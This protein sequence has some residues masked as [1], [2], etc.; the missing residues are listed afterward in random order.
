MKN[1]VAAAGVIG[2][3]G[4]MPV[5]A[6]E[7]RPD[8]LRFRELYKELVETNTTLSSGSC[9]LAA[10]RMGA[11]L[12]AAGYADSQL[13]YFS[14]PDHPKEGG[15]VAVLPGTSK[16]AKPILLLAHID[17][18][19]ARRS[20]WQRDP[21]TLIEENGYFYARGATDDK[22]MASIWVELMVRLKQEGAKPKRTV[23]LALTCGEET[24]DA[25]NGAQWLAQNRP[26]LLAAEFA[27]NEGG[28]GR[29]DGKGKL[30]VQNIQVGEK[31][32]Q[33]YRLETMNPGGHSSMP[34]RDNAIY[35][36]ADALA[37]I[38]DHEFPIQLN[39]TTRAFFAKAGAARGGEMGQAMVAIAANPNDTAAEAV[40]NRDRTFHSLLRTT[41]V[42]TLLEGGH[43][44]NALPQHAGA[45]INCRIFP[46]NTV[47]ATQ[48]ALEQA[49]GNPKVKVTLVA[50]IRPL[51]KSPPLDPKVIGPMEKLAA[52]YYPGVPVIPSMSTGASDSVFL[53]AIGI[54]VYGV[55]GLWL[56]PDANGAHGL[57][58]RMEVRALYT[59]RDYLTELV[60]TYANAS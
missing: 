41:C 16:T 55:P 30:L 42:A 32:V 38:R 47:E 49:I 45:N 54:P 21:F 44:N 29:T 5:A 7:P 40:L 24:T 57:N 13:T 8:Q 1:R 34:V 53:N 48:A 3:L 28:G 60:K 14:V 4:A 35:E 25:F 11:R 56:D 19:D 46:G 51:A 36:L 27:L 43:A 31:A 33:N 2:L 6:Q 23:K 9:T 50:P 59:G 17:V 15:L 52:K 22:A 18:V 26:D 20:D 39:D 10:E 37:K 58:E 12:K